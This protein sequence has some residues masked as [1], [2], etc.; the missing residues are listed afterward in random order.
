MR[1]FIYFILISTLVSCNLEPTNNLDEDVYSKFKLQQPNSLIT[2]EF[3][4][5]DIVFLGESHRRKQHAE[6]VNNLLPDLYR[7]GVRI[8]FSEFAN[9]SHTRFADSLLTATDFDEPGARKMIYASEWDWAYQEYVDLY[10]SAWSLNK[11]LKPDQEPFRIIG[12]QADINHHV[13]KS[14]QDWELPEKR[15]EYWNETDS[16]SWIAII[17]KEALSVNQKALVHCGHHHAFSKFLH[18]IVINGE[19]L[20]FDKGREGTQLL[21]RHQGKVSTIML[22]SFWR[23][24]SNIFP[25]SVVPFNGFLDSISCLIPGKNKAYGFQTNISELGNLIDSTSLYS[26]GRDTVYLKNICDAYIVLSPACELS[27]VN[28]I[29]DFINES[30]FDDSKVQAYPYNFHNDWTIKTMNDTLRE[31]YKLEEKYLELMKQ[32][33]N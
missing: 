17:E 24:K 6:F 22:H 3:K 33:C 11:S 16:T 18:P 4:N 32:S 10:K 14:S 25:V 12:L 8:L 20:G 29:P 1:T 28:L 7:N 30:N 26:V 27:L 15:K 31:W 2:S 19:F 21:H 5:S 23:D 13:I 9:Y